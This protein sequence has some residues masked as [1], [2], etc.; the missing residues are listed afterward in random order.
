MFNQT[1]QLAVNTI[2]TLSIDMIQKANSGHP[3]LPMGAAPMAYVL[4][5]R[6]LKINPATSR[7]WP[8]RDRFLLSAGHGSAMLYSLLHLAGYQVSLDD[9]KQFRQLKSKTPGHPEVLHTDGVEATTGPLGQGIGMSVGMAMAEA[10]LASLY[11]K[12]D[13]PIVDH[14]TYALCGDGD[15][16]EGISQE[17]ISLA[18]HLK[19]GKLILLYDSNDVSLD[20]PLHKANTE[21]TKGRFE[22]SGWQ[23]LLVKDGNDLEAINA[24]IEAAKEEAEKPTII[25]VKTVIGFGAPNAGT[26]KVHGAP[27]GE[28][29]VMAA[30]A[31]YGWNYPPFTVP[32]EVSQRFKETIGKKGA[33]AEE[34]WQQLFAKYQIAYPALAK[35]FEAAFAGELP[36][37]WTVD[38]STYDMDY[39]KASRVTSREVIQVLAKNVPG[40]WGGS[41][42][43]S[44][45]NNTL[46]AT[47]KDFE[48]GQYEGRNIWFGVR[49]FGM[50]AAMNGI[51]LHGG[52]RIYGATFF[53]FVD[54]LRPAIRL[55]A[56]QKLPVTFVLTHDT[57][58]VGEDGPTH[59]PIEQL[60]SL[61]GMPNLSVIRP[62][63]ANEVVA[64]WKLAMKTQ[65][66]PTILVLTR[67][68]LP[69]LAGT[70]EKASTGVAKGGY[71]VSPEKG[72]KPDGILIATGSE[73]HLAQAAQEELRVKGKD[74]RVVSLP[75]FDLFEKQTEAYRESVLPKEVTRRVAIEMGSAF[76]WKQ[77]VGDQGSIIGIDRFGESGKGDLIVESLGFTVEHL[78]QVYESI[79]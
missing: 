54:Y 43:L 27:L 7:R 53:V 55:A 61:R 34:K 63:D 76:G 58:A 26:N 59:E 73:V 13:F 40:F 29:G 47:E 12:P 23:Y 38:L 15:F 48:P 39:N 11:N 28:E 66:H 19:L 32:E 56:L 78:V 17:S 16:M 14:Y 62:A 8:D 25:E 46:I 44:S 57:V 64:A 42:D 35:Q 70:A 51:A 36:A 52:T 6:H 9:L 24:A 45:S 69:V 77:Y 49:E 31:A 30:K 71:V 79:G 22:A 2:R 41:A 68:N 60:S 67:Q 74:V 72:E 1:D 18:G 5:T 50:A 3:G 21:S 75:S 20:G 65:D 10:H 33:L 4:W 37:N